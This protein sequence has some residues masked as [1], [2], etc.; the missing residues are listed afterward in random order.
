M[1]G[2]KN[3][4]PPKI[5][6]GGPAQSGTQATQKS[7]PEN[8]APSKS[9]DQALPKLNTDQ[10][11]QFGLLLATAVGVLVAIATFFRGQGD[12]VQP[13]AATLSPT[14]IAVT[15]SLQTSIPTPTQIA[16]VLPSPSLV[17][18]SPAPVSTTVTETPSTRLVIGVPYKFPA[19]GQEAEG[20]TADGRNLWVTDNS[21]AIFQVEPSGN[22]IA[23]FSAPE[24]TPEGITWDGS[25]FWVFTSNQSFIYHFQIIGAETKTLGSFLSPARVLG[26]DITQDLS[27][28]GMNLWYANQY[29]VYELDPLGRRLNAFSHARNIKGLEWADNNLWLAYNDFPTNAMLEKVDRRGNSLGIFQT[30]I[31][32]IIGLAWLD[33]YLWCIGRDSLGGKP[34]VYKL[35]ISKAK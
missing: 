10:K 15:R 8:D 27:W 24:V 35:D 25:S 5:K 28:D 7:V 9:K 2:R 19:P 17:P 33:G 26:G 3:R 11:I 34:M 30:P 1:S 12:I 4:T 21:G 13:P 18:V 31:F 20:I 29:Q 22:L 32:E 16:V 23:T 6:R 14:F